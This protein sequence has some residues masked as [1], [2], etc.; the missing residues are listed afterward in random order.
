MAQKCSKQLASFQ[1]EHSPLPKLRIF[2]VGTRKDPLIK[3]GRLDEATKDITTF[4]EELDGKPYYHSIEW[5]S[6]TGKSFFLIDTMADKDDRASVNHLHKNLSSMESS[7]KLDVPVVWFFCQ[8]ITRCTPK[9]FFRLH[10]L[11]A[12]CRKHK[13]VDGKNAYSQFRALLQLFSLLGFYSFFNLKGVS[14]KDNFV[15]TDTRVFLREVSKLLAVQFVKPKGSGMA[16]FKKTKILSYTPRLFQD[17]GMSQE[18]DPKWFLDALQHLGI[19]SQS[20]KDQLEYFIPAVLPQ[21]SAIQDPP[22][23]VAPLCFPYI[24]K[25]GAVSSYSDMPRGVFLLFGS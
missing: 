22:A 15:C 10:D 14:D 21:S 12:F 7:L 25:E 18:M 4:L 17:L 9:K 3:E 5:D 6:S 13:F 23:S 11:E 2:V 1:Q 24:I 16:D 8:E 19:V 20:S